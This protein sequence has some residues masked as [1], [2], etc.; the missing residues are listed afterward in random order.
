VG[1]DRGILRSRV[2]LVVEDNDHLRN[3]EAQALDSCGY[4]VRAC[5]SAEEAW[6]IFTNSGVDLLVTDIWLIGPLSG[7]ALARAVKQSRPD[8]KVMIVS[9]DGDLLS[10][11]DCRGIADSVLEKPFKL[12]ELQERAVALVPP[13][14]GAPTRPD[15]KLFIF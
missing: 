7:I 13:R 4:E 2:A 9:T 6:Q 8:V 11:E 15:A 1:A 5:A 10:S 3:A 12:R 14:A